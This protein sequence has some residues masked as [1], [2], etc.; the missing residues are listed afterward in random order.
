MVHSFLEIPINT[1]LCTF[2]KLNTLTTCW[3][4]HPC[5]YH[6]QAICRAYT[7]LEDEELDH[8]KRPWSSA[9]VTLV[10]AEVSQEL[11]MLAQK[12]PLHSFCVRQCAIGLTIRRNWSRMCQWGMFGSVKNLVCVDHK[13]AQVGHYV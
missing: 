13:L 12:G 10:L 3:L 1:F 11:I 7:E 8:V 6:T 4:Y 5:A 2:V 9:L